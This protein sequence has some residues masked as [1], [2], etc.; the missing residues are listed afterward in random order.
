LRTWTVQDRVGREIYLTEERWQH[1]ITGHR[2]LTEHLDDVLKT[3]QSGRR[4]QDSVQPFKY[5]YHRRCTTLPGYY[6]SI[7]VVVLSRG[8]N[9]YVVTAWPEIETE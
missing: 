4:R 2:A 5:F 8:D 3:L 1:I 6:N 9:R 7:T